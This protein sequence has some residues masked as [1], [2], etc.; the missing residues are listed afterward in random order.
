MNPE[1]IEPIPTAVPE[2]AKQGE[3]VRARWVWRQPCAWTPCMPTALEPPAKAGA[4]PRATAF[5]AEHGLY[6]LS[7][8]RVAANSL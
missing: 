1:P 3:A 5:F 4:R 6:R 8:A 7:A 2:T